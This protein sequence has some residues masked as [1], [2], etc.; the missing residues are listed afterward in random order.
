VR[1][2]AISRE[3]LHFTVYGTAMPAGSKRAFAKGGK[4]WVTDA[5]PK[6]APWKNQV[7]QVAGG[8]M[9]GRSL[10]DGPL[11][12]RFTFFRARPKG[13]FKRDGSLS[14]QGHRKPYPDVKPDLTK[15]VRCAE[16]ALKGV[17]WRD[18]QQVVAHKTWKLYGEPERV[19][20]TVE[21]A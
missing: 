9:A 6:S 14:A 13:H 4:A 17:V 10:M 16:D 12:A 5:N 18:D 8:A 2:S 3:P 1:E 20:I 7:A 11:K 15:L 19:V 21:A